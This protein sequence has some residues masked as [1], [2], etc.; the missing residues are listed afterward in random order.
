M[1]TE[2]VNHRDEYSILSLNPSL[3]QFITVQSTLS[4]NNTIFLVDTEARVSLIKENAI[5]KPHII[6]KH[7]I[8]KLKGITRER[9]DSLGSFG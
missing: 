6:N 8:I 7:D 1:S 9:I 2:D 3:S 4:N 5:L